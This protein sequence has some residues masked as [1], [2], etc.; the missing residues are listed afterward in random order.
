MNPQ[1]GMSYG[2]A[3]GVGAVGGAI[4]MA[5]VGAIIN[6][7]VGKIVLYPWEEGPEIDRLRKLI[8]Q[9]VKVKEAPFAVP[10]TV[11]ESAK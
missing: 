6:A 10:A 11:T 9:I 3:A 7:D 8:R 1:S 5:I 2:Q 4:G